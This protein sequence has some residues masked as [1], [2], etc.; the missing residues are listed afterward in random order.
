MFLTFLNACFQT[1]RGLENKG[2]VKI[3]VI[4]VDFFSCL[5]KDVFGFQIFLL[6]N[7]PEI[8]LYSA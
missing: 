8:L 2:S 5:G 4:W 7:Y 6:C 1:I 3:W